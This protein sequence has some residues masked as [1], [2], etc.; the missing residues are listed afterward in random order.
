MAAAARNGIQVCQVLAQGSPGART[1]HDPMK[2]RDSKIKQIVPS[3][4]SRTSSCMQFEVV[5]HQILCHMY[6]FVSFHKHTF[7]AFSAL[8]TDD[9]GSLRL[10]PCVCTALFWGIFLYLFPSGPKNC[11]S[12]QTVQFL[13]PDGKRYTK[14]PREVQFLGPDGKRYKKLPREVQFLGPDGKRYNKLPC[15]LVRALPPSRR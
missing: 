7:F 15:F 6:H 8:S 5:A 12:L 9:A 4:C 3:C 14:L 10:K 1:A 13:G 11:T 2:S